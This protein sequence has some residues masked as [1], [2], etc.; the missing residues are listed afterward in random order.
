MSWTPSRPLTTQAVGCHHL[1]KPEGEGT[2]EMVRQITRLNSTFTVRQACLAMEVMD[3][4]PLA[5][6][7][8][9]RSS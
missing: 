4:E 6:H 1:E 3:L 8:S 9:A 5:R 2:F 7:P